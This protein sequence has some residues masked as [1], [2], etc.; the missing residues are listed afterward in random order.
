MIV[1]DVEQNLRLLRLI[2]ERHG[3]TITEARDGHEAVALFH[4]DDFDLILMDMHMPG[5]DGL[6][7]TQIIRQ[8]ERQH[9]QP[10]MPIIALTASVMTEDRQ[11]AAAAGMD[12][13]A[14]KPL[15][16][17]QLFGEICRI[18]SLHP[19]GSSAKVKRVTVQNHVDWERGAQQLGSRA[20]YEAELQ[21]FLQQPLAQPLSVQQA[22]SHGF[23]A[24]RL[25]IHS[26]R[27]VAANLYLPI[28]TRLC[29]E[30]EELLLQQELET[31]FSRWDELSDTLD[32]VRLAIGEA[33]DH[34]SKTTARAPR[35]QW[36]A[37]LYQQLQASLE[38]NEYDDA[39]IRQVCAQLSASQAQALR[40][41]IDAF[42]FERAGALLKQWQQPAASSNE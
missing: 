29:G 18:F 9:Q 14:V 39:L 12:G 13:F 22:R 41:A 21:R 35:A 27:G 37:S 33:T 30:F 20:V 5:M 16:V 4:D 7:A 6:Q 15:D 25:H 8:H 31:V 11:R 40:L 10:R 2:L 34:G 24:L 23:D 3:H 19:E 38:K 28:L 1:D 26:L 17:E 42:D 32:Q 36:D